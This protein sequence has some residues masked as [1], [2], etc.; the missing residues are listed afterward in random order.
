MLKRRLRP[1]DRVLAPRPSDYP[2][3]YYF[4]RH[5]ISVNYLLTDMETTRRILVVVNE[6][7]QTLEG[8]L[9]EANISRSDWA[10]PKLVERFQ[11]SSLFE[12]E[13]MD[14]R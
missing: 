13:R 6:P 14:A 10:F 4:G 1:G 12:L 2:L 3:M 11:F 8:L 9:Q 7:R 5:D